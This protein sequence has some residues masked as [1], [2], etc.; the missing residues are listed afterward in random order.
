MAPRI[1]PMTELKTQLMRPATTS[2]F[3]C[4]F[5]SPKTVQDFIKLRYES[6]AGVN[7]TN[8][9][10]DKINISCCDASLPGSSL[11]TGNM[12]DSYTGVTETYAYRRAYDNRADFTF[13]VDYLDAGLGTQGYTTILFFESWMSYIA[14]ENNFSG[15]QNPN[16]FYRVNFPDDYMSKVM[17]INKFEKEASGSYLN[18]RFINAYPISIASM[19]VSYESSQVL[20]CTVSFSY[21]RYVVKLA[22]GIVNPTVQPTSRSTGQSSSNEPAGDPSTTGGQQ[23]PAGQTSTRRSVG[24]LPTR[25]GP[26]I[27]RPL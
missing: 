19:P 18:Y 7:L 8:Y 22:S 14:G 20:K 11:Q 4:S 10:M 2:H 9:T 5:T 23:P 13:Y 26:V 17:E 3:E 12:T 24:P 16:Y 25:S 15:Q 21:Q 6:G 27:N 1:R